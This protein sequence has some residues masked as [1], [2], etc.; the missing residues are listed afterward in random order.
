[1]DNNRIDLLVKVK[2]TATGSIQVGGGYGSYQKL[3]VMQHYL[4]D[5]YLVLG[6]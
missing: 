2:E 5:I 4:I 1:V 6:I 3:M